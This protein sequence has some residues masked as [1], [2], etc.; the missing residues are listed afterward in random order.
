MKFS[1]R[2]AASVLAACIHLLCSVGVALLAAALVFGLWYPFPYRE[3][4][5]GREL[6]FLVIAVDVICGPLLTM[7]L[8]NPAKPHAEL[9]RDLGLVALIQLAA[10]GY[11]LWTV[12][13]ARPLFLVQEVD[14]FKVIATPDL[15][16]A[17][18]EELSAAL[19]PRW[20]KGPLTVATRDPKDI[21][22]R[23]TVLFESVQGGRD[24]AERPEFYLPYEGA[25]ALK[26]LQRAK[27]LALFLQKHP[28]QQDTARKLALEKGADMAQW[29]YLPVIARQDWIA[30]LDKHAQ[31]QGFLRGD[32]F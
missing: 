2:L 13:E 19:Q 12:R 26:S 21:Q 31:I 22:E 27:P 18:T 32:G 9:W 24:Y 20:W 5:G 1:N 14:R 7:V 8:F 10:L 29:V 16:G 15:R 17:S 11:G 30:V 23:K 4:S 28:D 3:L 25:A 6:F